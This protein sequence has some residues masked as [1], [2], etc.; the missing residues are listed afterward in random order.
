MTMECTI[1]ITGQTKCKVSLQKQE[2]ATLHNAKK[3]RL[4]NKILDFY[5]ENGIKILSMGCFRF[6]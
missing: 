3:L 6:T 4:E 1:T 5:Q 2:I